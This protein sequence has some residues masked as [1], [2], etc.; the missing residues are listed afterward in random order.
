MLKTAGLLLP[1]PTPLPH[2]EE[3]R[4]GGRD[5]RTTGTNAEAPTGKRG[6]LAEKEKSPSVRPSVR[7]SICLR[8]PRIS[9]GPAG[10][11]VKPSVSQG[12]G[13]ARRVWNPGRKWKKWSESLRSPRTDMTALPHAHSQPV[14][15]VLLYEA[16]LGGG[17]G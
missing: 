9:K 10:G 11:A 1:P 14:G 13:G 4:G 8:R 15:L 7:Q 17:G 3:R 16:G 5:E 12:A 6:R 2:R